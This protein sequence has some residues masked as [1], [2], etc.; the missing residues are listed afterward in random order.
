M[1][2]TVSL[3]IGIIL[4]M[5]MLTSCITIK[6]G[7]EKVS[8]EADGEYPLEVIDGKGTTMVIEKK[9][10]RIV[11]LTLTS[12]EI[13][14]EIAD[15]D[16][17]LALSHL[18]DDRGLSNITEYAKDIEVKAHLDAESLIALDPD[19]IIVSDWTDDNAISQLRDSGIT[20]YAMISALG[21]DQVEYTITELGRIIGEKDR[22]QRVIDEMDASLKYVEDKVGSLPEEDRVRV[23]S[24]DSFFFTYGTGTSFDAVASHAG[25]IN[26]ASEQNMIMWQQIT[27]EEVISLNPQV[28]LLP[29]WS[30]EGFDADAFTREFL[31]DES[32]KEVDAIINK[33]VFNLPENHMTTTSQFIVEGVR[34]L[35]QA[36]YPQLFK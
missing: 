8:F 34:D 35:A 14:S 21:I 18:S 22:A 36:V 30:Y 23:L 25:V 12:D 5:T 9:P 29:S 32:L 27:K 4:I 11:S 13:L 31:G 3:L 33:R 24:L 1:K 26:I 17:I 7:D 6:V 10:L 19:I 28:I 16:N 20:V 15:R 2:K